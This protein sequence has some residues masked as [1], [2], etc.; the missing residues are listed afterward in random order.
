MATKPFMGLAT[1]TREK[2]SA[3][4]KVALKTR[5]PQP[6]VDMVALEKAVKIGL[7][8]KEDVVSILDKAGVFLPGVKDGAATGGLE[9]PTAP[10][11]VDPSIGPIP[12]RAI[13]L[14][15]FPAINF[16]DV[17]PGWLITAAFI[18]DL[19]DKIVMLDERIQIIAAAIDGASL[20]DGE[21]QATSETGAADAGK[22]ARIDRAVIGEIFKRVFIM[23][24][25]INLRS[26]QH[27]RIGEVEIEPTKAVTNATLVFA[28]TKAMERIREG[29]TV[30]WS[31]DGGEG[32]VQIEK[33]ASA[34]DIALLNKL[35]TAG[36]VR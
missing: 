23:L 2:S 27:I 34:H 24:V 18:N 28:V 11:V 9:Q 26:L 33:M 30:Q 17:Q 1:A 21:A 8:N 36:G 3:G 6:A 5:S 20:I 13:T 15:D 19:T 10:D 22:K 16:T 12:T 32:E 35:I 31:S 29:E 14:P 7:L 4:T 25:G